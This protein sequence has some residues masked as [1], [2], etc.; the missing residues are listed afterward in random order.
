M[1]SFD[2]FI[3]WQI[4][5]LFSLLAVTRPP[6]TS[7]FPTDLLLDSARLVQPVTNVR[8]SLTDRR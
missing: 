3:Q 1:Y 6:I 7:I 5:L 8:A 4:Y 2:L